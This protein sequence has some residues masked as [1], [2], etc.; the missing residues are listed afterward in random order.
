MS[1]IEHLKKSIRRFAD[2]IPDQTKAN[3]DAKYNFDKDNNALLE[4]FAY[5]DSVLNENQDS[6]NI[7]DVL[8]DISEKCKRI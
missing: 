8:K 4:T 7:H 3:I 5:V 1:V 2:S 6:R